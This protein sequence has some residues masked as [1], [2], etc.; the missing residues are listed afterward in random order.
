MRPGDPG[1]NGSEGR[2][3]PRMTGPKVFSSSWNCGNTGIDGN[4]TIL[5]WPVLASTGCPD[6]DIGAGLE[7]LV[8]FPA[9]LERGAGH[10][11]VPINP[12][13]ANFSPRCIF[14]NT[15]HIRNSAASVKQ[16]T[17]RRRWSEECSRYTGECPR[18]EAI[19]ACRTATGPGEPPHLPYASRQCRAR[20]CDNGFSRGNAL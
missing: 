7:A 14:F 8:P 3:M 2:K 12:R 5:V 4:Q 19:A 17:A 15:F 20:G 1:F 13:R 10:A 9:S 11:L 16:R 18:A 6:R